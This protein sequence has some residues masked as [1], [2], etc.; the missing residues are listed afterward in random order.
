M[1]FNQEVID[2]SM[3]LPRYLIMELLIYSSNKP[4]CIFKIRSGIPIFKGYASRMRINYKIE[5]VRTGQSESSKCRAVGPCFPP[6]SQYCAPSPY[7]SYFTFLATDW[8]D[9]SFNFFSPILLLPFFLEKNLGLIIFHIAPFPLLSTV[10]LEL[11]GL[12]FKLDHTGLPRSLQR[13][14]FFIVRVEVFQ[15]WK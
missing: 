8:T 5:D 12:N 4:F 14:V 6:R 13:W 15:F 3:Y 7:P 11:S 9:F 1:R 2:S 10:W